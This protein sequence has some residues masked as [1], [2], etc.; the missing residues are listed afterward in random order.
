MILGDL[1]KQ[2]GGEL[3]GDPNVE[4]SGVAT[5]KEA[6]LTDIAM[7][8]DSGFLLEAET[9]GAGV[10]LS[11]KPLDFAKNVIVVKQ[12]RSLLRD[13]ILIFHPNAENAH[14]SQGMDIHPSAVIHESVN[15]GS[16]VSIGANVVIGAHCT[17]GDGTV[18]YPNVSIYDHSQIGSRV[19]LHSGVVV[20]S[21]GFGFLPSQGQWKKIPHI[22]RAVLEDDVELFGNTVISRGCLGD[23]IIG[24][25]SKLDNL[26]HIAHN[27]EVGQHVAL[28][29]QVGTLGGAK[30]G[31]HVQVGG[32]VG[33]ANVTIGEGAV[34]AS[35]SGV[36]KDIPEK[37]F[38]SGFPAWPHKNELKLQAKL[39]K[40]VK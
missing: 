38:V 9:S 3:L 36:T 11:F 8:A 17:I 32:Q 24:K 10:F 14:L 5:L 15:L 33:I 39:R 31:N 27:V 28:A 25:G 13:L 16:Q 23:T 21:D 1:A 26:V 20:G 18:I 19:I 34:V 35:K 2:L 7:V 30:I 22:G 37:T 6:T 40:L 4:I 12:P 29:G